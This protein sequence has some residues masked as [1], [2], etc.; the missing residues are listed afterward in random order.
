[1]IAKA[2]KE[3]KYTKYGIFL[4]SILSSLAVMLIAIIKIGGGYSSIR[5]Q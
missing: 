4:W 5:D 3:N 2:G 1:M